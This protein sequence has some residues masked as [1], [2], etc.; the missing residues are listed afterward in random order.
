MFS[1]IIISRGRNHQFLMT[2]GIFWV[3]EKSRH[4][5]RVSPRVAKWVDPA[6]ASHFE[7]GGRRRS[8]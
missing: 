3:R 4:S 6:D 2:H 8:T 7:S 5:L 1:L